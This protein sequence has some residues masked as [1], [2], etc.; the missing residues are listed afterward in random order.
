MI[1]GRVPV[2]ASGRGRA[3]RRPGGPDTR[4]EILSAARAEFSERAYDGASIRAIASRAGV[5]PALVHHYFGTK[6][7]L[8]L[9]AM[10]VPFA[11]SEVVGEIFSGS[12][13]GVGERAVRRFLAVWGDPVRRTPILAMLRSAMSNEA[14]A[15]LLRQFARRTILTRAVAGLDLPDRELRVEAAVSHLIGLALVRYVVKIEPV[16]SV[17][18]DEL[19]VLVGPVIQRYFDP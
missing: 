16:A 13:D 7:Q 11:P 1:R 19:A 3:G 15:A 9:E 8:F 10:E 14:A 18:D 5:D 4:G 12:M 17:S 2:R 6:E